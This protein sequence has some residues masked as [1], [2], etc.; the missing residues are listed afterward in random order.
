M[1]TDVDNGQT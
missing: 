1:A